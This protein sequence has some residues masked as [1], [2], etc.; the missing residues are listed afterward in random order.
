MKLQRLQTSRC[1]ETWTHNSSQSS[2]KV[3]EIETCRVPYRGDCSECGISC[4]DRRL[5][6]TVCVFATFSSDTRWLTLEQLRDQSWR[7]T[8]WVGLR[9]WWLSRNCFIFILL[10]KIDTLHQD[11]QCGNDHRKDKFPA[12]F[13][14]IR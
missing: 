5:S 8:F 12:D 3:P 1:N 10:N 2:R 7:C 14:L 9:R 11:V 6:D 4:W 13:F